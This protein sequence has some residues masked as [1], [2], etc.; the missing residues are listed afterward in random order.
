MKIISLKYLEE[1]FDV[2]LNKDDIPFSEEQLI[3][4]INNYDAIL[5]IL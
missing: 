5:L 4:A 3:E 2:S 1:N